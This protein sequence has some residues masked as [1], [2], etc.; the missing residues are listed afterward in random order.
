MRILAAKSTWNVSISPLPSLA[1][2]DI[3]TKYRKLRAAVEVPGLQSSKAVFLYTPHF[4]PPPHLGSYSSTQSLL[5]SKPSYFPNPL[6]SSKRLP[7]TTAKPS[8]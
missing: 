2:E 8:T 3:F 4:T 7:R 6:N 1:D 5:R